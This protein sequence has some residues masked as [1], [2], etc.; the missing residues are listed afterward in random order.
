M[1]LFYNFV[2]SNNSVSEP[3]V[4]KWIFPSG[5]IKKHGIVHCTHLR[6]SCYNKNTVFFRLKSIFTFTNSVDPGEMQRY[7]AFHLGLH[8]LY[9]HLL[10]V[11]SK[12]QWVIAVY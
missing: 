5:L 3:I 10:R 9:K 6:V 12:I 8:C 7:T 11:F 4:N 1:A 2:Q